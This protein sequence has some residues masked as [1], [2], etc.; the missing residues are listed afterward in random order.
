MRNLLSAEIS[1][2][3]SDILSIEKKS[4][5]LARLVRVVLFESNE[6]K[7]KKIYRW[8]P[9][10]FAGNPRMDQVLIQ[11]HRL[12]SLIR[13]YLITAVLMTF[14]RFSVFSTPSSM[15]F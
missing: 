14:V 4:H 12:D 6:N 11:T 7:S 5:L 3:F 10:K 15:Y 13:C 1:R 9:T 2:S 8:A